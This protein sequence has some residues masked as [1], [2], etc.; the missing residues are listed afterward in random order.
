MTGRPDDPAPTVEDSSP[1]ESVPAAAPTAEPLDL[2]RPSVIG[3]FVVQRR[4]GGGGMGI[5]YLAYDPTLDRNVAVKLIRPGMFGQSELRRARLLREAQAL[6]KVIHPNVVTVHEAGTVGDEVYVAMEYVDGGTLGAWLRE[7]HT[8]ADVLAAFVA[9]GRGLA[10]AHAAGLVHRDFKP[11]NA[12]VGKDGRVRVTDF[13]LVGVTDRSDID[14]LGAS[15]LDGLTTP[16][17]VVG[18]PRY[19]APEQH[20]GRPVDARADQFAFAVALHEALAGQPPFAG[21][22]VKEL[23]DNVLAENLRPLPDAVPRRVREAVRRALRRDPEARWPSMTALCAALE[24]RPRATA[25]RAAAAVALVAVAGLGGWVLFGRRDEPCR[26]AERK[27][28]GAWD[29]GVR[30][31][32]AATFATAGAADEL[33]R[34]SK[35]LDA[36]AG[37]W[38]AMHVDACEATA[39]RREQSA[40]VL[41]QRMRCLDRRLG[42]MR[43][44]TGILAR[45]PAAAGHAT[46]AALRLERVEDCADLTAL[47][48]AEPP[49]P[50]AIRLEVEALRQK[51]EQMAA[52]TAVGAYGTAKTLAGP[53][54]D[55]ARRLGYAPLLAWALY[56]RAELVLDTDPKAAEADDTEAVARSAEGKDDARMAFIQIELMHVIGVVEQRRAEALAMRPVVEATVRRAGNSDVLRCSFLARVGTILLY[57]GQYQPAL[58]AETDALAA[59]DRGYGAGSLQSGRID[60]LI[61]KVL[62]RIHRIDEAKVHEERALA[63]FEKNLGPDAIDTGDAFNMLGIMAAQTNDLA[64]A[65]RRFEKALAIFTKQ[66]AGSSRAATLTYNLGLLIKSQGNCAEARPYLDKGLALREQIL[67]PD[68]P[69]V[70]IAL[71]GAAECVRRLGDPAAAEPM[72]VRAMAIQD[73]GLPPDHIDRAYV[74]DALADLRMERHPVDS[75]ALIDRAIAIRDKVLGPSADETLITVA[76]RAEADLAAGHPADA[77]RRLDA[78]RKLVGDKTSADTVDAI[79]FLLARSLRALG[80]DPDRVRNL[81]AHV[82]ASAAARS[83]GDT[84][85]AVDD[86]LAGKK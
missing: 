27:L 59:C 30:R 33:A 83:A 72:L 18:T 17:A 8:R 42:G 6:G 57:D 35:A 80:R 16:G 66:G 15:P 49:A 46:A 64:E 81:A 43:A 70:A 62:V 47:A 71:L 65:R 36:Y 77:L 4:L 53:I 23:R 38:T 12:L 61:A 7:G 11:E 21:D 63:A 82:R 50:P 78:C 39:V 41:D 1:G 73:K 20:E 60:T 3:R 75:A 76:H 68:H 85:K 45:D 58:D 29:D 44:L 28:A 54:V 34:A 13:G 31:A 25:A 24:A 9:A 32:M 22:T 14:V 67:G 10:A 69:D 40:A 19:M 79:D 48:A 5:V 84:V 74:L 51:I 26:G 52:Y 37:A 86:W 56:Q 55:E 2:T